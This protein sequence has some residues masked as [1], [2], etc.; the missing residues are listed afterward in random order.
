MA[1]WYVE[2]SNIVILGG[3]AY[4]GQTVDLTISNVSTASICSGAFLEASNFKIGGASGTTSGSGW[5]TSYIWSGGTVTSGVVSVTFTNLGNYQ[6]IN[7]K[8]RARVTFAATGNFPTS[9]ANFNVDIDEIS[10]PSFNSTEPLNL[11]LR[12]PFY[13]AGQSTPSI[14]N[15]TSPDITESA[16]GGSTSAPYEVNLT[17]NV[18]GGSSVLV[19]S[20]TFSSSSD[21][22]YK[23]TPTVQFLNVGPEHDGWYSSSIKTTVSNG[24]ISAFTVEVYYSIPNEY[25]S[26]STPVA[27]DNHVAY[28]EYDIVAEEADPNTGIDDVTTSNDGNIPWYGGFYSI[29]VHGKKGSKY[30]VNLDKKASLTSNKTAHVDWL[31]DATGDIYA[32]DFSAVGGNFDFGTKTWSDFESGILGSGGADEG[33]LLKQKISGNS[34]IIS[35]R[36]I[37]SH[38]AGFQ[39]TSITRRFD[40]TIETNVKGVV[41]T[42]SSKVPVFPGDKSII[43]Y[44]LRKVALRPVTY[45]NTDNLTISSALTYTRPERYDGD[46]YR[47]LSGI[48]VNV[49][50]GTA[51]VASTK[52]VLEEINEDIREDMIVNGVGIGDNVKV[53]VVRGST[54]TLSASVT[55]A[56]NTSI[57]FDENTSS[58]FPYSFTVSP[59]QGKVLS[60]IDIEGGNVEEVIEKSQLLGGNN[61]VVRSAIQVENS[62]TV[63]FGVSLAGHNGLPVVNRFPQYPENHGT[64][65]IVPGM[66]V[67]SE[68][69]QLVASNGDKIIVASVT[70]H[71]TIELSSAVTI[72]SGSINFRDGNESMELV[73]IKAT[74]TG[75]DIVISGSLKIIDLSLLPPSGTSVAGITGRADIY[76]D[77]LINSHN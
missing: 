18:V 75:N 56:D 55:V 68:N 25:S 27:N 29:N 54:I 77:S 17:G 4:A 73:S 49:K 10:E 50:G 22:H 66:G 76:L 5:A 28:V 62:T 63:N 59:T 58:I 42:K 48:T 7:N 14:A 36:G 72:D 30:I 45:D 38:E 41:S 39:A 24:V 37:T 31:T 12:Y 57:R 53:I 64:R 52:L 46:P 34:G 3:T 74:K 26:S 8:I 70:D 33:K 47:I 40:V 43:Q 19:G 15:I 16:S 2:N 32:A 65:G 60:V 21:Y 67:Y 20:V 35:S 51:G 71:D 9:G 13:A 44:G 23:D 1:N 11:K 6:D 69:I 61:S